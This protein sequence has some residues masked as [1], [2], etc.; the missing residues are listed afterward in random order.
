[1]KVKHW[2][3]SLVVTLMLSSGLWAQSYSAPQANGARLI[4]ASYHGEKY[5]EDWRERR[6]KRRHERRHE[7]RHDYRYNDR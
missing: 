5:R 3:L 2:V 1:M 7:H 4:D 6:H